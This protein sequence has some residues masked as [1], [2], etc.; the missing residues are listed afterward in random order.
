MWLAVAAVAATEALRADA[1]HHVWRV[2]RGD[3]GWLTPDL[4]ICRDYGLDDL[5]PFLGEITAT[6][7]VQAA[8][9]EAETG[10]ILETARASSGLVRAVVGWADVETPQSE[11]FSG[12]FQVRRAMEAR[13]AEA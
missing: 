4:P 10:F 2:S 8:P 11:V 7:L 5:R 9:T 3:Y 13:F 6:V 12:A 1:H